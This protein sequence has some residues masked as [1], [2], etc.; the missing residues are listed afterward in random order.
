MNDYIVKA[1]T[2]KIRLTANQLT[3]KRTYLEGIMNDMQ[4]KVNNLKE[5]FKSEAG[6]YYVTQYTSVRKNLQASLD[7]LSM[8]VNNMLEAADIFDQSNTSTV[9][10]ANSLSTENTF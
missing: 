10:K 4:T 3:S 8:I 6:N 5:Y 7:E 2:E 9:N 1:S